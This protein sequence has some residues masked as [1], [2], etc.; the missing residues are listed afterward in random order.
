MVGDSMVHH[1][2]FRAREAS[3]T[4]CFWAV[5]GGTWAEMGW[6]LTAR[7]EEWARSEAAAKRVPAAV[8]IWLGGNDVYRRR[9][10]PRDFSDELT[11]RVVQSVREVRRHHD[12]YL[13]GPTPRPRFDGTDIWESTPAF[14]LERRLADVIRATEEDAG[15]QEKRG[16][17]VPVGRRLCARKRLQKKTQRDTATRGDEYRVDPRWFRD[18][19]VHLTTAGYR[20]IAAKFPWWLQCH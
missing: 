7:V 15:C 19:G 16:Q 18:D 14:R 5:P 2:P 12:V 4:L 11:D 3:W 8:E 9:S 10:P 20:Q 17:L 1:G 13:V 6:T